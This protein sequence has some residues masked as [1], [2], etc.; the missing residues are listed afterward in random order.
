MDMAIGDIKIER[1]ESSQILGRCAEI[2]VDAY[3]HEPWNDNWTNEKALEKLTCFY[4]SPKFLGW[5]VHEGD[6]LIGCCVGNIEPYF[7]GDY[8]YLKEMFV[9]VQSQAKGV[10]ALLMASVKKHL[11]TIGIDTI[12]LF[13]SKDVFPFDFY[14]K[15]GFNEMEGMRMMHFSATSSGQA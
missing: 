13:T 6:N 12:I 2:L 11:E 9:L 15:A 1:I 4:N 7:T 14:R 5:T 8:F 10:G 3:N